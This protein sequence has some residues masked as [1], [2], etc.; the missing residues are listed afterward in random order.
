MPVS[1]EAGCPPAHDVLMSLPLWYRPTTVGSYK[2]T[3]QEF[4]PELIAP[5]RDAHSA[6]PHIPRVLVDS[7]SACLAEAG[8]LIAADIKSDHIIELGDIVNSAGQVEEEALE[9]AQLRATG[10]SLFKCV[11]VGG[12]DVAITN[13]VVQIAQDRGIGTLVDDF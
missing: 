10:Y 8:E 2:P 4:P 9:R 11:G 7:R 6:T 5:G 3:M 1:E 13:L 12:M